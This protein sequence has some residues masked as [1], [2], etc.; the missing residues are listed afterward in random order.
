MPSLCSDV[1]TIRCNMICAIRTAAFFGDERRANVTGFS[2]V[3]SEENALLEGP[4][5]ICHTEDLVFPAARR[6]PHCASPKSRSSSPQRREKYRRGHRIVPL[7]RR[8][9]QVRHLA[10][11]LVSVL[12][13]RC[14]WATVRLPYP[15]WSKP[16]GVPDCRR[17]QDKEWVWGHNP[18]LLEPPLPTEYL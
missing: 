13:R 4:R 2:A 14:D 8:C 1:E 5:T 18:P 10:P 6:R 3:E 11:H 17:H 12:P 15:N 7:Y 9:M 16:S